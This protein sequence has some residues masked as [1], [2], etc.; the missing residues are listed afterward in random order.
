MM[1]CFSVHGDQEEGAK[2]SSGNGRQD[3]QVA[4]GQ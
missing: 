4:H 3:G 2:S 1:I